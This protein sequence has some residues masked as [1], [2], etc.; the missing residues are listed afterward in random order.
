VLP[1]DRVPSLVDE[2]GKFHPV[3]RFLRR[4]LLGRLNPA[5]VGAELTA[6]Y[7][8]FRELVVASLT[9]LELRGYRKRLA[10]A[11]QLS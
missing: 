4:A 5:E 11:A 9:P 6:Q 1:P 7:E 2:A 3:G 10:A 8:R